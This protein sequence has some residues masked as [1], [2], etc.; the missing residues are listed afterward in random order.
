MPKMKDLMI[1]KQDGEFHMTNLNM[2]LL[3]DDD[4]DL[5]QLTKIALK[6]RGY[7]VETANNG[8]EGLSKLEIIK[9]D[10]IILDMNMPKLGG[11]GFYQK[12]CNGKDHPLYP[13]LVLTARTNLEQLLT[14]MNID[15]FIAK[16]FEI[17]ELL[18]KVDA[19]IEKRAKGL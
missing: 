7:I 10:L 12:I 13:V 8:L 9:P 19:I 1:K 15:G 6:S 4:I 18:R 3:I 2:I 17:D 11:L 14:Q 16:P 5:Q